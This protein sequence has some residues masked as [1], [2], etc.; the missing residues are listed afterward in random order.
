MPYTGQ[1][2]RAANAFFANRAV[3]IQDGGWADE[4][5]IVQRLHNWNTLAI[6]HIV[7]GGRDQGKNVVAVNDRRPDSL[8]DG[9]DLSGYGHVPNGRPDQSQFVE[10]GDLLIVNRE[11]DDVM[12]SLFEKGTLLFKHAVLSSGLLIEIMD[13]QYFHGTL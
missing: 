11:T 12:P 6:R 7:D 8:D 10:A 3:S 2:G 13:Q 4:A 9:S 5:I 1:I